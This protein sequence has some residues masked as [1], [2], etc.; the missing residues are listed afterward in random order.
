VASAKH[1]SVSIVRRRLAITA[2][3]LIGVGL[4]LVGWYAV[5]G[6]HGCDQSQATCD[7]MDRDFVINAIGLG[8]IALG[9]PVAIMAA[10]LQRDERRHH[11]R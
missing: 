4:A 2:A 9:L 7:R 5:W 1:R 6:V 8:S 3:V 10:L 11:G